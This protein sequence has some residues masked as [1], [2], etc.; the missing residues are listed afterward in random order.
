[1][2]VTLMHAVP[3]EAVRGRHNPLDLELLTIV[4]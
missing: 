4:S 2:F 1:M 3:M